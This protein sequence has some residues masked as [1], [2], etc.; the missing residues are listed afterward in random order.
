MI[1]IFT[2]LL[3]TKDYEF[4]EE[5][6]SVDGDEKYLMQE[7]EETF[8]L[9]SD[10]SSTEYLLTTSDDMPD[11]I[12]ELDLLLDQIEDA[13]AL[14]H[15]KEIKELAKKCHDLKGSFLIITPFEVD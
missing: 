1:K 5:L 15:V 11:L 9:L 10:F 3:Q 2:I 6:P 4:I 7:D 12:K 14:E 13:Q 8:R